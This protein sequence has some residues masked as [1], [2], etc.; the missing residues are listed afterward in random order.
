MGFSSF[1][2]RLRGGSGGTGSGGG[3][4]DDDSVGAMLRLAEAE[5]WISGG[6]LGFIPEIMNIYKGASEA[7]ARV[8]TAV[9]KDDTEL[10]K[11]FSDN[12]SFRRWMT[13]TV[14]ALTY[15]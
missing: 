13:D 14:F 3:K 4:F 10:F 7:F 1:F 8:M 11:Q 5:G 12:D 6:E 2:S 15:E 9:L